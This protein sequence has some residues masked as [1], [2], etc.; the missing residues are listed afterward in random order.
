MIWVWDGSS[1]AHWLKWPKAKNRR[2]LPWSLAGSSSL[3]R[4]TPLQFRFLEIPGWVWYLFFHCLP[5][6]V[7]LSLCLQCATICHPNPVTLFFSFQG[8]SSHTMNFTPRTLCMPALCQSPFTELHALRSM[9]QQ[10]LHKE[11]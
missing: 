2:P 8:P 7:P 10:R 11:Q 9:V 4:H 6:I 1:L 3:H 5:S